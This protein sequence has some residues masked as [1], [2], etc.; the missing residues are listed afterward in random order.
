MARDWRDGHRWTIDYSHFVHL[1]PWVA[2]RNLN[3]IRRCSHRVYE[4]CLSS[5]R[6]HNVSLTLYP[7]AESKQAHRYRRRKNIA[8]M[9]WGN[10]HEIFGHLF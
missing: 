5:L 2:L 6:R 3:N 9:Q 10:C 7:E 8:H 1:M 4:P